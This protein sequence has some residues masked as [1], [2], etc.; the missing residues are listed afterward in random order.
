VLA[1]A[2]RPGG[3][4]RRGGAMAVVVGGFF[5]LRGV[6]EGGGVAVEA[7]NPAAPGY[8]GGRNPGG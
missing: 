7:V 1:T 8:L 4:G 5:V 2:R 6:C 3:K